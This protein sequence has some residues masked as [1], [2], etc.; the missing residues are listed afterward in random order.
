M[1]KMFKKIVK[2]IC[3]W[4]LDYLYNHI[5]KDKNGQIDKKELESF[6]LEIKDYYDYYKK[7][8]SKKK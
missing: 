8:Y 1:V 5:D 4:S 2:Q 6:Y 7:F 3:F